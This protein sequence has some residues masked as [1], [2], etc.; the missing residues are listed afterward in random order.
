MLF[1][2][3]NN[4]AITDD[5]LAVLEAVKDRVSVVHTSD[6]RQVGK[7][8]PVIVGTGVSPILAVFQSLQ[9]IGFDGGL[10]TQSE[11]TLVNLRIADIVF[12]VVTAALA[13]WVM[14]KYS[15]SEDRAKEI[16]E[17]LEQRRGKL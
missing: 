6:I 3:A 10:A 8:E 17:E 16:K 15:L 13:I 14:W 5:P 9:A 11:E 4:Q 7:F 1:D 12:P 2:T